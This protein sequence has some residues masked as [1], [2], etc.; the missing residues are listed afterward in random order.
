MNIPKSCMECS[1]CKKWISNGPNYNQ[2][3]FTCNRLNKS[4]YDYYYMRHPKCPVYSKERVKEEYTPTPVITAEEIEKLD[5]DVFSLFDMFVS[6]F[7]SDA[8]LKASTYYFYKD[9]MKISVKI[10]KEKSSDNE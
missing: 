9:G 10:E 5:N 2:S 4:V 1:D 8:K 7:N 3:M 6:K